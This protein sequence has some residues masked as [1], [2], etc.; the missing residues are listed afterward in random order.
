MGNEK[1]LSALKTQ[2]LKLS[3]VEL[4]AILRRAG[5]LSS[6]KKKTDAAPADGAARWFDRKIC[7][8]SPEA[9]KQLEETRSR[10]GVDDRVDRKWLNYAETFQRMGFEVPAWFRD[11]VDVRAIYRRLVDFS[12]ANDLP[13]ELIAE[14][15]PEICQYIET[16]HM[17]PIMIIG[18]KGSGKTTFARMTMQ[19]AI[20]IPVETIKA[21]DVAG[22]YGLTGYCPTYRAADLGSL[23]RAQYKNR[24]L[25]VGYLIDE[26]DKVTR[27]SNEVSIDDELLSV[28]DESVRTI[29]DKYLGSVLTGLPYCPI[30]F[31][32]NDF[33]RVNPVLADRCK[34][35]H[36]PRATAQRIQSI[37]TKYVQRKLSTSTYSMIE[38]DLALLY[39]SIDTLVKRSVTSLRKHQELVE[40]V[41][42]KAFVAAMTSTEA[43]VRVSPAMF[44][45]AERQIADSEARKVGFCA[46]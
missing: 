30:F 13:E 20:Q 24:R 5:V 11:E 45:E 8:L 41:L 15:I 34:V 32:G 21:P 19:E 4:I 2:L 36:Y 6:E 27:S 35:I 17:R 37:L 29:E 14:V 25:V 44:A 16:G 33:N 12:R 31:T 26:I 38:F 40:L 28:T 42:N 22:G 10:V 18:E 23:A 3:D 46:A 43:K 1:N 39:Q 9:M 7:G